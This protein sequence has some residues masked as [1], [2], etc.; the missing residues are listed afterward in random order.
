MAGEAYKIAYETLKKMILSGHYKAGERLPAERLLCEQAGVSR[1]TMRHAMR[2]LQEQGLVSRYT[3][4]GTFVNSPKPQKIPIVNFDYSKSIKEQANNIQRDVI[5]TKVGR[6]PQSIGDELAIGRAG[7]WL[8]AT[9]LDSQDGTP[10]AYDV[11]YI[12][13][14]FA[15]NINELILCRVDFLDAW[16]AVEQVDLQRSTEV[17]EAALPDNKVAKTLKITMQEPVLCTRD[18]AYDRRDDVIGIFDTVYRSDRFKLI[19]TTN[20]TK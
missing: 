10:I 18:I 2:L 8:I 13:E 20:I 6:L 7:K 14:E 11:V 5:A 3:G 1:I 17:V 4:K 12:P 16:Q 9:R 15:R 19:S